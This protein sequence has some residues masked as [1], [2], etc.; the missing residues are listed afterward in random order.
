[1]DFSATC[2]WR[3]RESPAHIRATCFSMTRRP[4]CS[5]CTPRCRATT[6][7]AVHSPLIPPRGSHAA[8]A[9]EMQR[10]GDTER[11]AAIADERNRLAREIH[12]GL[13]QALALM[14]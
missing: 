4:A 14:V 12:D 3:S 7:C 1:M 5:G 8:L 13:A 6:S 9:L 10:L 2:S 11:H